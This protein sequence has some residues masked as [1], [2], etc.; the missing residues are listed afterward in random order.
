M[1]NTMGM[2]EV[3]ALAATAELLSVA[4]STATCPRTNSDASSG[5]RSSRPC[6]WR[7][8]M[9]KFRPA[10]KPASSSDLR[11]GSRSGVS[12]SAERPLTYPMTG[13]AV[14]AC[15]ANGP[16]S[17]PPPTR[18]RNCRRFMPASRLRRT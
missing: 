4:T 18:P 7:Y 1:P 9:V 3:A 12:E 17:A 15:A 13:V 11:K 2:V 6:A 8:S 10:T 5:S 16:A 14:C